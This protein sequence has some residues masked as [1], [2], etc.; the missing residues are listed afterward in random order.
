MFMM[1]MMMMMMM[2]CIKV[3]IFIQIGYRNN[4]VIYTCTPVYT[5][6]AI[7]LYKNTHIGMNEV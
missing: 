2:I 5:V 1:M 4:F 3:Q 7:N 6:C